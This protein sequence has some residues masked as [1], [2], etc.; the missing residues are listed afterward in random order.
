MRGESETGGGML[1]VAVQEMG[2]RV[3]VVRQGP[4]GIDGSTST[5][6]CSWS[7]LV[8]VVL[9]QEEIYQKYLDDTKA[10]KTHFASADSA[11]NG[12]SCCCFPSSPV[13][14]TISSS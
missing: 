10:R 4:R 1:V 5:M 9:S 14:G 7:G 6:P 8:N 2:E 12:S 11:T 3:L 13:P